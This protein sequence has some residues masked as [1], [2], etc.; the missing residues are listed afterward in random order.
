MTSNANKRHPCEWPGCGK[1][2]NRSDHL[3][4]HML[5]HGPEDSSCPRCSAIFKRQD[6]LDRHIARHRQKDEEAGGEGL[7]VVSTRKRMWRDAD[8]NVVEDRPRPAPHF[9]PA[10]QQQQQSAPLPPS[11]MMSDQWHMPDDFLAPDNQALVS[12]PPS[13]PSLDGNHAECLPSSMTPED[14]QAQFQLTQFTTPP[15]TDL[16]DF[17]IDDSSWESQNAQS[18]IQDP[19]AAMLDDMFHPDTASSFN[20]PFTTMDNYNWLLEV[21][22]TLPSG[23]EAPRQPEIATAPTP[24]PPASST[25]TLPPEKIPPT[26]TSSRARSWQSF[27]AQASRS[28]PTVDEISR[29]HVLDVIVQ[30][31][32]SAPDGSL[33]T[34]YHPLLSL[35]AM[36]LYCDL[37]FRQF[38][39]CYPL[40]HKARFRPSS[41]EPLLLLS[42]LLLGATYGDK[43]AHRLAVCIHDTMRSQIIQHAAFTA[44]PEL[45]VLQT[46]L[47]VECFGK[48]RAGQ[49]QHDMSHLFHGM[50]INLIRRS[51]CQSVRA[52]ESTNSA[53]D[54]EA[55][56]SYAMD[57][58]QRKR[59]AFLCFLWDTQHAV[60]FSQSLCM[61][62]FELR[63]T[64][65][66]GPAAWE[67]ESAE[68]WAKEYRQESEVTF[69]S[70]LKAYMCPGH[71][72]LLKPINALSRLLVLH[73]LM[74]IAW[75]MKRRDQT[76]LGSIGA[77]SEWKSRLAQSYDAWKTDFD[78]YCMNTMMLLK[79]SPSLKQEFIRFNASSVAIYHAAHIV[80]NV[81]ILDLQIYAGAQHIIGRPINTHDRERSRRVVKEWASQDTAAASRAAW[82]AAQLLRDG[83][84]NLDDWDVDKA[85]HYPWCLYIA[86]LTCWA[87]HFA[88]NDNEGTH[89]TSDTLGE[90]HDTAWDATTDMNSLISGMTGWGPE[91]LSQLAGKYSTTGLTSVV[92]THLSNIRWAVIYEGM[93]VLKGLIPQPSEIE[94]E[95]SLG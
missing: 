18:G 19:S 76:S 67:A 93:K 17:F 83:I 6:L 5:N 31:A 62:A 74:S 90:L 61:S 32:P 38:N 36:Q 95:D 52:T 88:H 27:R 89:R 8:G 92:A 13:I 39:V 77:A 65:P 85:F 73:G 20:M 47:L 45:W 33:I 69:L 3:Q 9:A 37:F 53:A 49:K 11:A 70:V 21:E 78:G 4:R 86:T 64:L 66:C 43:D 60:L 54:P 15:M 94:Y 46:I 79:D 14:L 41:A 10:Q 12:P 51:D 28:T 48:S 68:T 55:R 80:L 63:T 58:E 16:Y 30:S 50:L 84:M 75:D 87:F 22:K 40:I 34:R 82:H 81:E 29:S 24:A 1:A 59:V 71:R 42:V 35:P 56:W 7:G 44:T 72:S 91:C 23:S 2:F 25:A 26:S 57:V